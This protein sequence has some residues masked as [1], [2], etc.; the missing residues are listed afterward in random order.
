MTEWGTLTGIRALV[1]NAILVGELM[2]CDAGR[3]A[4]ALQ[5][6][7]NGSLLN[8][9]VHREGELVAWIRRDLRSS[10]SAR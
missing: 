7:I 8:W 10:R 2:R 6:T 5:A 1:K 9:A 4:S 3:L